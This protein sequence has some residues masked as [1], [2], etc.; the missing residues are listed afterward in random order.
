VGGEKLTAE[1]L[2]SADGVFSYKARLV[3][4]L[5]IVHLKTCMVSRKDWV[6]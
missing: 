3:E 1:E 4:D 6:L 2:L 5:L